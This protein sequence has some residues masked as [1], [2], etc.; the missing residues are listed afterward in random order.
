MVRQYGLL[1]RYILAS[2][3]RGINHSQFTEDLTARRDMLSNPRLI[4]AMGRLYFD[5]SKRLLKRGASSA[6]GSVRRYIRVLSQFDLNFDLFGEQ[7]T[8]QH[9]LEMLP[10]E[11]HNWKRSRTRSPQG[12]PV[13][14]TEN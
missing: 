7:L 14:P 13:A 1:A 2:S 6:R 12:G 11:F 4:E 10:D 8:P 5:E 3:E 9:V